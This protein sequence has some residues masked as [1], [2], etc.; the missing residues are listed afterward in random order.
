MFLISKMLIAG[1]K[2]YIRRSSR[3]PLLHVKGIVGA[4]LAELGS[5]HTTIV[6]VHRDNETRQCVRSSLTC[7]K[8]KIVHPWCQIGVGP[9]TTYTATRQ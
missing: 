7:K 6:A 2:S 9:S 8:R 1:I 3:K 4:R 5:G